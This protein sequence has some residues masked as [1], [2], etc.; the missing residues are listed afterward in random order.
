[1]AE[2]RRP[3][4][5]LAGPVFP[6]HT[7]NPSLS[8]SCDGANKIE[9]PILLC[10]RTQSASSANWAARTR[11]CRSQLRS[12]TTA[13][14]NHA[15]DN[16]PTHSSA[17]PLSLSPDKTAASD[18]PQHGRT[19]IIGSSTSNPFHSSCC[20]DAATTCRPSINGFLLSTLHV[21]C[22]TVASVTIAN[23]VGSAPPLQPPHPRLPTGLLPV[24]L[25]EQSSIPPPGR[26]AEATALGAATAG[27]SGGYSS[28]RS[29]SGID[30]MNIGS[31]PS[32][33][34]GGGGA[35][36]AAATGWAAPPSHFH[37]HS[38]SPSCGTY[39][40]Q[41]LFSLARVIEADD[42]DD[43]KQ[44]LRNQIQKRRQPGF[45][46]DGG[47]GG[48]GGS[49]DLR[50]GADLDLDLDRAQR[51]LAELMRDGGGGDLR[52]TEGDAGEAGS[53][54]GGG[55]GVAAEVEAEATLSRLECGFCRGRLGG[56][57]GGS[58][59]WRRSKGGAVLLCD[60]CHRGF[61]EQCCRYRGLDIRPRRRRR[62]GGQ[63]L[64]A[65]AGA[66]EEGGGGGGC[67]AEWHHCKDCAEV[68]SLW[69]SRAAAGPGPAP[70]GRSW[71]LAATK[72]DGM[73]GN[74]RQEGLEA[75]QQV[76]GVV[77]AATMDVYGREVVVMDIAATADEAQ[78]KGHF[79]P[80]HFSNTRPGRR[81]CVVRA[82]ETEPSP[83][84]SIS[85]KSIE[86]LDTNYCDDFL[87]TSSPA[88]EQT[89]RSLARELKRGRYTTTSLYQPGVTYSDGFRTFTGPEGFT[90]QRWVADNVQEPSL[91]IVKMRMLDKGT[92][93]ISWRLVGR[94]GGILL[95]VSFNT[96]CEHNLLTGRITSLRESWDLSRCPPPAALL[97]TFNRYSWS[98]KQ[99]VAD[100]R[101]GA[102]KALQ[103]LGGGG[104]DGTS[105]NLP[106]DPTRFY[107]GGDTGNQ[108]IIAVGFL[109]ALLYLAFKLFGALEMLG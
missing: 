69:R 95:D 90:R 24:P 40:P 108:D 80:C 68:A 25:D 79:R 60:G 39:P 41:P 88:V 7:A 73:Y 13:T 33:G 10:F 20:T 104:G 64:A 21:M 48:G 37:S 93:E 4:C 30:S 67:T 8:S 105:T 56:G 85:L 49:V 23:H 45:G 83:L 58:R 98:A 66:S 76:M 86:D 100:A 14:A 28:S 38:H 106:A 109:I 65:A 55:G 72:L 11:R 63:G 50:S 75:L 17:S 27:V 2:Q 52:P 18:W 19:G 47:S 42:P 57:G 81:S 84:D 12:G 46:A 22:R 78:G 34:N 54:G 103:K 15:S 87:C 91:T 99:A 36:A 3:N 70:G 61:H 102:G 92:S 44:R 9:L 101:D 77:S 29:D 5:F 62:L 35:A 107:Q 26:Q 31:G 94:L 16:A 32:D 51:V 1:M 53:P 59:S 74:V 89:V 97:A 96:T 43:P 82:V 6:C 71:M